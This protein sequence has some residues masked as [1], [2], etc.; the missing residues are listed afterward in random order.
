MDNKN[1]WLTNNRHTNQLKKHILAVSTCK[2]YR[3]KTNSTPVPALNMVRCLYQVGVFSWWKTL[4]V[5]E[6]MCVDPHT[7]PAMPLGFG[8][9]CLRVIP[10]ETWLSS[11]PVSSKTGG[12]LG[13]ERDQS[14]GTSTGCHMTSVRFLFPSW[15]FSL[16]LLKEGGETSPI[17]SYKLLSSF[18]IMT[19]IDCAFFERMVQ[20]IPFVSTL[21]PF[22]M[23]WATK[24]VSEQSLW[25]WWVSLS[26]D[27]V[28][29]SQSQG[30]KGDFAQLF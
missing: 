8:T 5:L 18:H 20:L 27:L 2:I 14:Q 13:L 26:L 4:C 30:T 25:I 1:G 29:W 21:M 6:Y 7:L 24:D 17:S 10:Q 23:C 22:V 3:L 16:P 19:G 12:N 11:K 15:A 9:L 28:I